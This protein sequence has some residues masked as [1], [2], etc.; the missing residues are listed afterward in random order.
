MNGFLV[1]VLLCASQQTSF[2]RKTVQT[3]SHIHK[4]YSIH[5]LYRKK[6]N[7]GFWSA[8]V[9]GAQFHIY[10][11]IRHSNAIRSTSTNDNLIAVFTAY[12][13]GFESK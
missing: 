10:N 6:F 9:C 2:D 8:F 13:C 5:L 7:R 4:L 3:H 12:A 1:G 11:K